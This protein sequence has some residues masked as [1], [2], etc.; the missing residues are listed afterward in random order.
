[1][2]EFGIPKK[3]RNLTR[4]CM[5]GTQYQIKVDQPSS[6]TFKVETGTNQE[7]ALSPLV[8]NLVLEKAVREMQKDAT[9]VEINQRKV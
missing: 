7:D 8:F 1:M 9:G 6:E 3:L 2:T 4:M 5:G